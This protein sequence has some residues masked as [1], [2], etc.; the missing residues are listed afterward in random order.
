MAK[1]IDASFKRTGVLA[2]ALALLL[3]A[4]TIGGCGSGDTTKVMTV[5][6]RFAHAK[7]LFDDHDYLAAINDLTVITLQ[8][9]GSAIAPDAQFYLGECRYFREEYLLAA[10]EYSVVKLNYPANPRVADAMYK[11]AMSYYNLSPKP[12]LDQQYTR[13]AIDEF[14]SFVEYYPANANAA[15][16]EAK[17]RD[18]TNRLAKKQYDTARL[19]ATMQYYRSALFYYDDV[20]EKYH[21]TEYAPLAFISKVELLISRNRYRDAAAEAA[22]FYEKYPNSVLRAR[23]DALKADIDREVPSPAVKGDAGSG[24]KGTG[25]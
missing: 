9:Q 5:E 25:L 21:D 16:A 23:M 7:A 19:Y 17:I 11:T 15:D 8:Y 20:I 4:A 12:A 2:G 24:G 13:K 10:F 6:E 3:M 22:R 1:P 18:L 14:Q